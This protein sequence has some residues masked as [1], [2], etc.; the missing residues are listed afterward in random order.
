MVVFGRGIIFF[1]GPL[2]GQGWLKSRDCDGV[3]HGGGEEQGQL[4]IQE[5]VARELWRL[6]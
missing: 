6:L 2:E 5:R 4:S 3:R 1:R